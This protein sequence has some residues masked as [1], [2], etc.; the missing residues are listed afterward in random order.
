MMATQ[1]C[2]S[3]GARG[4]SG[5]SDVPGLALTPSRSRP[6]VVKKLPF[7]V[8]AVQER[9]HGWLNALRSSLSAVRTCG[10]NHDVM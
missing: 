4:T 5:A 6:K 10:R 9:S 1:M 3:R 2:C 8:H 7:I